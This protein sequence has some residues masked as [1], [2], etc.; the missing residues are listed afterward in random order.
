[1]V[2]ANGIPLKIIGQ[3]LGVDFLCKH[4]FVIQ[5]GTKELQKNREPTPVIVKKPCQITACRFFLE[6]TVV[7]GRHEMIIPATVKHSCEE[8]VEWQLES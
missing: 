3:Q 2:T 7:P 6:E 4:E 8:K 5:L 1:M